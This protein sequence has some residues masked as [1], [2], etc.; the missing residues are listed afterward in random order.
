MVGDILYNSSNSPYFKT[1]DT[2]LDIL[3]D[4][5]VSISQI[6]EKLVGGQDSIIVVTNHL[7]NFSE[8]S[9]LRIIEKRR[10]IPMVSV[11]TPIESQLG[12][13]D[14]L[15]QKMRTDLSGGIQDELLLESIFSFCLETR[16]SYSPN[17]T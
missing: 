8:P 14:K 5:A 15:I 11:E 17:G 10:A 2:D 4:S 16:N 3:E 13:L 7:I 12:L 6:R 9:D 1:I